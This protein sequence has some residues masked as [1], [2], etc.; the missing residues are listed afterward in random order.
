ME[1]PSAAASTGE[2]TVQDRAA[3]GIGHATEG[4]LRDVQVEGSAAVLLTHDATPDGVGD[5]VVLDVDAQRP[6]SGRCLHRRRRPDALEGA[7]EDVEVHGVPDLVPWLP[8][9]LATSV[10]ET[11]EGDPVGPVAVDGRARHVGDLHT[12]HHRVVSQD[13][14]GPAPESVVP[15]DVGSQVGPSSH[16]TA[17]PVTT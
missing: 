10:S 7:A 2:S 15:L 5:R 1:V 9:P 6:T 8:P 17:P 12:L 13:E 16:M 3:R 4:V 14:L 11:I